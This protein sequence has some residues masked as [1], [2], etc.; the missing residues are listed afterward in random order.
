VQNG[1]Y[2]KK[3]EILLIA[4]KD[5][6]ILEPP[7]EIKQTGNRLPENF[8]PYH[9]EE[10]GDG[11]WI[12]NIDKGVYLFQNNKLV[13][14][15]AALDLKETTI[16]EFFTDHDGNLWINTNGKGVLLKM[17]SDFKNYNISSGLPNNVVISLNKR[18]NQLLIGTENGIG[19]YE[20]KEIRKMQLPSSKEGLKYTYQILQT[21][22]GKTGLN[23]GKTFAFGDTRNFKHFMQINKDIIAYNSMFVWPESEQYFW[24]FEDI[25]SHLLYKIDNT[26][27]I[28]EKVDLSAFNI[29]RIYKM[30]YWEGRYWLGTNNGFVQFNNQI[31]KY[32]DSVNKE[33]T[34]EV[35]DLLIDRQNTLWMATANG[36]FHVVHGTFIPVTKSK[37]A[38][39]NYCKALTIDN[40]GKI[41][42][43]TW[44]G[45]FSYD[46]NTKQNFNIQNGLASKI[47]NCILYDSVENCLHIGTSNGFDTW[48]PD[49]H[50]ATANN[51]QVFI[52]L[53][54]N[55]SSN[56]AVSENSSLGATKNQ[57]RFYLNIPFY[58][59]E[60]P[61]VY[62]YKLDEGEWI[63]TRE[64]NGIISNL[65]SGKHI[66]YARAR[67]ND[68]LIS[69]T[70][71]SI[72]FS[73]KTPFYKTWWFITLAVLL[74]QLLAFAVINHFNKKSKEKKLQLM[75]KDAEFAALKQKAFTALL[76][77]HFIFN[78]LNSIQ[79]FINKNDRQ[80]ANK[81]LS[82]F[83]SLIRK[84]FDSAQEAFINLEDELVAIRLYIQLEQMRFSQGFQY[85]IDIEESLDTEDWMIPSLVL[86][87]LLE[88]AILHGIMQLPE[89]GEI[90]I[91]IR[92][93]KTAL[94]ITIEDNGIGIEKSKALKTDTKHKSKGMHLIRERLSILSKIT[95][96]PLTFTVADAH[97]G[98]QH[99]GTRI[100]LTIPPDLY[101]EFEKHSASVK[102]L[103]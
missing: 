59:R 15:D 42:C 97:P 58:N 80:N 77:P 36:L 50:I 26:N 95:K 34:G 55:D 98:S 65:K 91:G 75:Q 28:I 53:T 85:T 37:T 7:L 16:N 67:I 41:W 25:T 35:F 102:E 88:N 3:K 11:I 84:N 79:M 1:I 82:D 38:L 44:D 47:T 40:T 45:I 18:K 32:S 61:V 62:E 87:P 23:I 8:S 30:I 2:T 33:K 100:T 92:K 39:G 86:Q 52:Q 6:L 57:F 31:L 93:V 56:T 46:G 68:Q 96:E 19:I 99:C 51:K 70:E 90:G 5:I 81:Y 21:P 63:A 73:I 27:A 54:T 74:S 10:N 4:G 60:I 76:N 103:T 89:K 83:A 20:N 24:T 17:Q 9:L 78:A 69:N 101:K 64:P 14:L 66:F 71:S 12:R 49:R 48:I 72:R 13:P 22:D 94:E 29:L 43:A